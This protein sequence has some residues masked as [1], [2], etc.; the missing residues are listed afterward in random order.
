MLKQLFSRNFSAPAIKIGRKQTRFALSQRICI[1]SA[2]AVI[3]LANNSGGLTSC[4][5]AANSRIPISRAVK[6]PMLLERLR[7]ATN[8]YDRIDEF[9]L[10]KEE[11]YSWLRD[12]AIHGTL[13]KESGIEVYEIYKCTSADEL[14]CI[15][16]FGSSLN[17]YPGVVHGGITGLMFDNSFGWL[18]L[19]S[20]APPSV[21]ANLNINYR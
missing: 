12:H 13:N 14:L 10:S 4:D 20:K 7:P 19:S 6:D 3:S 9:Y 16:K 2:A 11:N 21:T 15:I 17:G 18:L 1:A 8:E 5:A